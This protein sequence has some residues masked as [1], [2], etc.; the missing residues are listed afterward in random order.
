MSRLRQVPPPVDS[1]YHW[2]KL[3]N[4]LF[5][6]EQDALFEWLRTVREAAE[7]AERKKGRAA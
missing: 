5:L 4:F 2:K 3:M 6:H 7:D 1:E